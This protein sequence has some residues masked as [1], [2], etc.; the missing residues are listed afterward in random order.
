[1][2]SQNVRR[3]MGSMVMISLLSTLTACSSMQKQDTESAQKALREKVDARVTAADEALKQG[4]SQQAFEQLDQAIK[5]DPSA[6][7]PWVRKAQIHFEA[8]QYG[9]AINDAQEVLQRDVN[10][11]T[12]QSILAVSGLRVSAEALS[13]L[14]KVNE[15]K[16]STRNEAE[17]VA[18]LIREALGEPILVAPQP[19]A[20][21][22]STKPVRRAVRRAASRTPA[23]S[24]VTNGQPA[25][26]PAAVTRAAPVVKPAPAAKP[27]ST[28][29]GR[30]NPFGALQ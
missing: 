13:H 12:A 1:M 24:Q 30:A 10:D 19:E 8:R 14:R 6:K 29:A 28:T 25:A 23:V 9:H 21:A 27:V 7:Q 18:K 26:A 17:S 22:A 11:L 2:T 15:V 16:G 20:A 4:Q 3:R 5:L